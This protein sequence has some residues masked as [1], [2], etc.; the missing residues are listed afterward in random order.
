[1]IRG[2]LA[3]FAPAL[4]A[5]CTADARFRG[6]CIDSRRVTPEALFVAIRGERMDGHAFVADAAGD[7]V[8]AAMVEH[9]LDNALP[10]MIVADTT[11]GLGQLASR[12]RQRFALPVIGV[13]GSNGKTTVKEMLA[14]ILSCRGEVLATRGN[15]NNHIGMPLTLLELDESHQAA[16]IEMGANHGG[17]IALLA[18]LARPTVGLVTN[19]G[20]AHLEGFGSLDDVARAKGE[21]F[22]ALA[23]DGVAVINAD[24]PYAGLWL[25]L[26]GARRVLRFGLE[27]QADVGVRGEVVDDDNGRQRFVLVTPQGEA[28]VSLPL[29]G[30]HN[31]RNALAAAAAAL[32]AGMSPHEIGAGLARTGGAPG[33]LQM[34]QAHGGASLLDDTY[35]AN[36]DS[37]GVALDVLAARGGC[38]VLVLGDMAELGPGAEALHAEMGRQARASGIEHLYTLGELSAAASEA[39]GAGA[40]HGS[41]LAS[42]LAMLRAHGG[43]DCTILVKGS[44][45]MQMERVVAALSTPVAADARGD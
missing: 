13:T 36:P 27:A 14:A 12:W 41:D 2:T 22:T 23:D 34:R 18:A 9:E 38:R 24:D 10:Q 32:A 29:P 40:G 7:G 20:R 3:E 4:Q 44:R 8:A 33:R 43:S 25:E 16:V 31:I 42:L 6:V 15:F 35:N 30:R 26:A 1:M 21:M 17:E 5:R 37:L 28:E 11:A 19:A 45:A 39:F